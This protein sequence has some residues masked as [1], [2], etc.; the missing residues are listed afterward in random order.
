MN[1]AT[2]DEER[3]AVDENCVAALFLNETRWFRC[4]SSGEASQ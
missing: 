3:L 1:L 4:R 2:E